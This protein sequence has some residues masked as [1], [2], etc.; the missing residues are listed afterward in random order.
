MAEETI[1]RSEG[2]HKNFGNVRALE[3]VD[4]AVPPG[5]TGLIGAN[6]AGKTTLIRILLGLTKPTYGR[7]EVFGAPVSSDPAG[8]RARIGYMP[9]GSCLPADQ[10]AADFVAYAA[11]LAG[12]PNV[13]ARRRASETLFLVGLH[14]ERFRYLGDFS[15]GMQ[16]RVKLA[17]SIVH[18][19]E[20][21]LL[22]EPASGLD[23]AGREQMLALIARFKE[24][25]MN[26]LFSSHLLDDIEQTCDW[27]VML[28]D[29][30]LIHSAPLD[31]P[32][33]ADRVS[34]EVFG[35]LEPLAAALSERGGD[36]AVEG[37]VIT[38]AG[39]AGDESVFTLVRDALEASGSSVRRMGAGLSRLE[40]I[41]MAAVR[42]NN[43]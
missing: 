30:R 40:D 19:P 6:G 11:E 4:L 29:G 3:G 38:V 25:G 37:R 43:D 27:V 33:R 24:F 10:T 17:Q 5:V 34:V 16:Q 26:V 12:I 23:P 15:T 31:P 7:A 21:V 41:L 20:L 2:L 42:E 18:D 36:V 28:D 35:D 13:E 9:E 39:G 22:D 1:I 14:E 8:L 32:G